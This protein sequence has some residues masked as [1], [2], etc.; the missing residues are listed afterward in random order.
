MIPATRPHTAYFKHEQTGP[1]GKTHTTYSD[2]PVIAWDE[3]GYPLVT[4]KHGRLVVAGSYGNFLYVTEADG[5]HVV[6]AIPGG[7]WRAAWKQN[8][9]T[10]FVEPVLAW[11]VQADG[12]V[13]PVSADVEGDVDVIEGDP[14]RVRL[15]APNQQYGRAEEPPRR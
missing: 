2:L 9:G 4:G 11:L 15:I 7:G 12:I 6:A 13:K 1:D 5:G 8:D 3:D 10:E 14:D